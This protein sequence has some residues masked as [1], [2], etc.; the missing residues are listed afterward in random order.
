MTNIN[1]HCQIYYLALVYH[2][3]C[4]FTGLTLPAPDDNEQ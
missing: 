3:D 4:E 1:I 2:L